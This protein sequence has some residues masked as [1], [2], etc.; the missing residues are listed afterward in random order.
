M[1]HVNPASS[2]RCMHH[3][4]APILI[5]LFGLTFLLATLGYLDPA[6]ARLAW[7]SLI[8]LYGL[9]KFVSGGCKCYERS[10]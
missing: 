4:I 10:A 8:V 9:V 7:P 5:I 1:N 2:C 6:I 3:K